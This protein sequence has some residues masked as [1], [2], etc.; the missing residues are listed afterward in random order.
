[1]SFIYFGIR[2][3]FVC[4]VFSHSGDCHTPASFAVTHKGADWAF[5]VT[6]PGKGTQASMPAKG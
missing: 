2:S 5:T 6:N 1:M 4:S 3:F